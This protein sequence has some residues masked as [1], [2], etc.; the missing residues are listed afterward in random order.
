MK[1]VAIPTAAFLLAT[2]RASVRRHS[3]AQ[4]VLALR[5]LQGLIGQIGSV[6]GNDRAPDRAD[7]MQK[8]CERA[9]NVAVDALATDPP[10]RSK[11]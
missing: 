9:F 11:K 6:Y 1:P 7:Q 4:L 3:R 8:L 5:E 10:E 2:R